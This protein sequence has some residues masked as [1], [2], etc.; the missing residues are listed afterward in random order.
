ME[1]DI[2]RERIANSI[3]KRRGA[4]DGLGGLERLHGVL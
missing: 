1:H 3:S 2:A 4:G